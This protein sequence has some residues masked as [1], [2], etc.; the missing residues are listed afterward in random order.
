MGVGCETTRSQ[1]FHQ[2][3]T[4]ARGHPQWL[5]ERTRILK[6]IILDGS[7]FTNITHT[8]LSD[9]CH[10]GIMK[11][12]L[13]MYEYVLVGANTCIHSHRDL[14]GAIYW[15]GWASSCPSDRLSLSEVQ[16]IIS[17]YHLWLRADVCNWF[18]T[19]PW[20]YGK[21]PHPNF[22][23]KPSFYMRR[24][25]NLFDIEINQIQNSLKQ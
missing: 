13:D 1:L 10:S 20:A 6:Y 18:I 25:L 3:G 9:H 22:T 4:W 17:W 21:A 11:L 14:D 19:S 23:S 24:H 8:R 16:A 12:K 5:K 15:A 2:G 7:T